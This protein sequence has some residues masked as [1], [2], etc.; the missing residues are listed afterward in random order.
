M[1]ATLVSRLADF[2]AMRDKRVGDALAWARG[3]G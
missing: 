2:A 3:S 1:V